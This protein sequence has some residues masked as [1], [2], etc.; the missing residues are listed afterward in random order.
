MSN[1][2]YQVARK[3]RVVWT[4]DRVHELLN[5]FEDKQIIKHLDGSR[6][7]NEGV[8]RMATAELNRR[9]IGENKFT[10]PEIRV[11]WKSLKKMFKDAEIK[12]GTNNHNKVTCKFYDRLAELLGQRATSNT[13]DSGCDD[14]NNIHDLEETPL[15]EICT[16]KVNVSTCMDSICSYSVVAKEKKTTPKSSECKTEWTDSCSKLN[17][18]K[19]TTKVKPIKQILTVQTLDDSSEFLFLKSIVPDFIK[20]NSK[21]QRKFKNVLLNTLDQL[22]DEQETSSGS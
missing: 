9:H 15:E 21:N 4:D 20:L 13:K 6:Y 1:E 8:F 17:N 14:K 19:T 3:K 18:L 22:L 11:K 5:V 7:R 10:V 2:Q 16:T 12:N